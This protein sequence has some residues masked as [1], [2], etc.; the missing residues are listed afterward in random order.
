MVERNAALI[1]KV[2]PCRARRVAKKQRATE[3]AS[4]GANAVRRAARAMQAVGGA[5][6][7][8]RLNRT[9]RDLAP[10]GGW[11]GHGD[12]TVQALIATCLQTGLGQITHNKDGRD[13]VLEF[14]S[15][16]DKQ[17]QF[18]AK[19]WLGGRELP[20]SEFHE[21][22]ADVFADLRAMFSISVRMLRLPAG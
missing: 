22:R 9:G 21:Y 7:V 15:A 8:H 6:T 4:R 3:A 1:E 2:S 12:A 10:E 16:G 19:P 18:P 20:A 14:S 5:Q 11:K 13:G 17:T